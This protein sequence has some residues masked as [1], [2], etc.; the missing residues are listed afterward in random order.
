MDE[1]T[2]AG[3]K[4]LV[5]LARA[6][7]KI[8]DDERRAIED[9]LEGESAPEHLSTYRGPVAG[10]T[11][12]QLLAEPVDLDRTIAAITSDRVRKHVYESACAFVFVDAN[13]TVAERAILEKLRFAFGIE[14]HGEARK[15]FWESLDRVLGDRELVSHRGAVLTSE[16]RSA[17]VFAAVVAD[18]PEATVAELLVF[19][20]KVAMARNIGFY[21]G[22]GGDL[23]FWRTFVNNVVGGPSSSVALA[24]L[25]RVAP[26]LLRCASADAFAATWALGRATETHFDKKE[27]LSP[28]Q[29]R[30]L[31][32]SLKRE[33]SSA[34]EEAK[35]AIAARQVAFARAKA[36]VDE[37]LTAGKVTEA[38][39]V[40]RLLALE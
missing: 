7:G 13:A 12:D 3:I 27:A 39:Y 24:V 22:H 25:S 9:A 14:E 10:L 23:V 6:D 28:D 37:E 19:A 5:A 38:E 29:L 34:Y 20:N 32:K 40:D 21:F 36:D 2:L 11:A 4:V 17:A 26:S 16:I 33:A 35:D 18:V 8:E 1:E 15:R 31:Y 30:A